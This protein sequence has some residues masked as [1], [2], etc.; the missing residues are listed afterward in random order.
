MITQQILARVLG[1][2]L[3]V[4]AVF[5][6]WQTIR[7]KNTQLE[8]SELESARQ[9]ETAALIVTLN[10][11]RNKTEEANLLADKKYL[12]GK[13]DAEELHTATITSLE[14]DR[15][16]LRNHWRQALRRAEAAEAAAPDSGGDGQAD[17]LSA[18]IAAVL[19]DSASCDAKVVRLQDR[20]DSYLVQINGQGYYD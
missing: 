8:L 14:R 10:E 1:G 17:L 13:K 2:L 16:Q 4:T 12:E 15:D 11:E 7:L 6:V 9:K 19:R 3:L 18:D 20:I 5:A